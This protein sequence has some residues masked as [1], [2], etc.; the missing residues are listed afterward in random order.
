MAERRSVGI[1]RGVL[2]VLLSGCASGTP[3][4]R[5]G[6]P[7][8]GGF[9]FRDASGAS[10]DGAPPSAGRDAGSGSRDAGSLAPDGGPGV[11]PPDAGT[12]SDAGR[13]PDA[14]THPVV[15]A[16]R[17][18]ASASIPCTP[19][20]G[21]TCGGPTEL[22][23]L[24]VGA[25]VK[26]CGTT[27]GGADDARLG[28]GQPPGVEDAVFHVCGAWAPPLVTAGFVYEVRV[29]PRD[30]C[31]S[32]SLTTCLTGVDTACPADAM[33]IVEKQDGTCGDFELI[34]TALP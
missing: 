10:A 34:F 12:A 29:L 17:T 19:I 24:P 3:P 31:E 30:G 16:G 8:D 25:T 5:P 13:T 28:C 1:A 23:A 18:D 6:P 4:D 7:G 27:C 11:A 33:F 9:W 21:T 32:A 20:T 15:D 14:G 22:T 2:V 26:F